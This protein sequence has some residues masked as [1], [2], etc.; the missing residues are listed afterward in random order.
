MNCFECRAIC[1]SPSV[2][3]ITSRLFCNY[4]R[5]HSLSFLE[6]ITFEADTAIFYF[7]KRSLWKKYPA[8]YFS[9]IQKNN[10]VVIIFFI[11]KNIN[12]VIHIINCVI[13]VFSFVL[14]VIILNVFSL[15]FNIIN[16]NT[17]I[18]TNYIS[19]VS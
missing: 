7:A 18:I 10:F 2:P 4:I 16:I 6:F 12:N 17:K 14:F 1:V 3:I 11:I 9:E 8:K 5:W 19:I 15:S 13:I